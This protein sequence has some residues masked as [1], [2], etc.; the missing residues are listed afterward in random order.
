MIQN[1]RKSYKVKKILEELDRVKTERDIYK[2]KLEELKNQYSGDIVSLLDAFEGKNILHSYLEHICEVNMRSKKNIDEYGFDFPLEKLKDPP[3]YMDHILF[4]FMKQDIS[5]LITILNYEL[6]NNPKNLNDSYERSAIHAENLTKSKQSLAWFI[7]L[8]IPSTYIDSQS[9]L[10][11]QKSIFKILEE[12]HNV[13][14]RRIHVFYKEFFKHKALFREQLSTLFTTLLLEFFHGIESRVLFIKKI[15]SLRD[16]LFEIGDTY[17]ENPL[18]LLDFALYFSSNENST[19][20]NQEQF[21]I[22]NHLGGTTHILCADF[23]AEIPDFEKLYDKV[24]Q[25]QMTAAYEM[26]KVYDFNN[27]LIYLIF[28]NYFL[29]LWNKEEYQ[30]LLEILI[31]DHKKNCKCKNRE[32]C[33]FKEIEEIKNAF[34]DNIEM[35]DFLDF[36]KLCKTKMSMRK[37]IDF[38][39]FETQYFEKKDH[40]NGLNKTFVQKMLPQL[41][42]NFVFSDNKETSFNDIDSILSNFQVRRL[43]RFIK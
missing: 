26:D 19:N 31:K 32:N 13:D 5:K 27:P 28:K 6:E 24:A 35:L 7:N 2:S 25:E 34:V 42:S 1:E 40:I 4:H 14:A 43:H 9:V 37:I 10:E 11:N 33:S 15:K 41:I 18:F 8:K 16:V 29:S 23:T 38:D 22:F 21:Q 12:K 20:N 30:K 36:W 3:L 39:I 17:T